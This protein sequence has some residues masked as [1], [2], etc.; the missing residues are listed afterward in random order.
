MAAEGHSPQ[1]KVTLTS[2][3]TL[4]HR[5]ARA[6]SAARREFAAGPAGYLSA[7]FSL[8]RFKHWLPVRFFRET[9]AALPAAILHPRK[10]FKF[11]GAVEPL[12][13]LPRPYFR[14]ILAAIALVYFGSLS[15]MA[16]RGILAPFFGISV[17]SREYGKIDTTTILAKLKYP[18]QRP[19]MAVPRPE[20]TPEQIRER[21]ERRRERERLER[22]REEREREEREKAEREAAERAKQEAEK[23]EEKTADSSKFGEINEKPIQDIVGKVYALYQA[24]GLALKG[25]KLEFSVM[26]GFTIAKDGSIPKKS[27]KVLQTSESK[28]IDEKAIE[29]LWNIGESHALGPISMLSSNS[30]KLELTDKFAKLTIT[31]FAPSSEIAKKKA[32]QLEDMFFLLRLAKRG[33]ETG[34]LLSGVRIKPP[35][36]NRLDAELTVSRARASEMMRARFGN[37]Q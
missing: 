11:S 4:G 35:A 19:Q 18:A 5:L 14:P 27:I 25:D 26:L 28:I 6:V 7:A 23:E 36:G 21:E 15:Y 2:D 30:I 8:D 31:G 3:S 29:I 34:E 37:N 13:A 10:F 24:G 33:T 1:Y 22:E 12:G 17:V 32:Q 20:L 9:F 16:Y